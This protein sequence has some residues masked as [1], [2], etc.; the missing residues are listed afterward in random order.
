VKWLQDL[1]QEKL[2]LQKQ[3]TALRQLEVFRVEVERAE[4]RERDQMHLIEPLAEGMY[5][6]PKIVVNKRVGTK[7]K[8]FHHATLPTRRWISN[9]MGFLSRLNTYTEVY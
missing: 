4:T 8:V 9:W 5:V 3:L 1:H 2:E 6:I 7:Q